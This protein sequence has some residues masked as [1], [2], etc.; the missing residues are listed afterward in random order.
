MVPMVVARGTIGALLPRSRLG[1][2]TRAYADATNA[3]AGRG[4]DIKE[5]E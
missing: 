5:T 4:G 3:G 1:S 2:G